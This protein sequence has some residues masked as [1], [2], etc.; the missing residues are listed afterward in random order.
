MSD[1][2]SPWLQK[3]PPQVPPNARP[4][5]M[6]GAGGEGEVR[7]G[8]GEGSEPGARLASP[9][10]PGEREGGRKP[11]GGGLTLLFQVGPA[12]KLSIAF[13]LP[14]GTKSFYLFIYSPGIW[15]ARKNA[16]HLPTYLPPLQA[17]L[18]GLGW[19]VNEDCMAQVKEKKKKN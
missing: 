18:S 15:G 14:P 3:A 7:T 8:S 12:K 1:S 2:S 6:Q 4:P 5:K 17:D 11:A 16:H 13:P 9:L 19:G 10:L